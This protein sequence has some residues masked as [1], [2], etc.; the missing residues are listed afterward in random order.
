MPRLTSATATSD[1]GP[2]ART[3]TRT[4]ATPT[5][6]ETES[7]I[8]TAE[9]EKG[10]QEEA[11]EEARRCGPDVG[12]PEPDRHREPRSQRLLQ[13][14]APVRDQVEAGIGGG[15]GGQRVSVDGLA[16]SCAGSLRGP[17]V[18]W[19]ARCASLAC[20]PRHV[21]RC[22]GHVDLAPIRA[23][24]KVL[25]RVAVA[26]PRGE[27]HG[28]ER[29]PGAERQ[30]DQADALHELRPVEP[31]D[32]A[33][34]R[35]DVPDRDVHRGLALVLQPDR[36]FSRRS[37]RRQK[38]LE[39]AE[40]RRCGWVLVAKPLE[41]LDLAR[42]RQGRAGQLPELGGRG[43]G[44]R[45]AE[46]QQAVRQV[47]CALA[48]FAAADDLLGQASEVLDQQDAQAD[49]DR[50]ELSERQRLH[51]LVRHHQATQALRIES[52]VGVRDVCPRETEDPRISLEGAVDELWQLAVV[53][54]GQVVADLAELLL[55]DVEV[56][57]EPLRGRRDRSLVLDRLGQLAV[58]LQEQAPVL[59]HPPGDRTSRSR[60]TGDGLGGGEGFAV[61]LEALDAEQFRDDRLR[62][63]G[64]APGLSRNADQ[65]LP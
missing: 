29:A 62:I 18:R 4:S 31:G 30:V 6:P 38:A 27:V 49:G 33:H 15:R 44:G 46:P 5:P 53:V 21:H 28:P 55:D 60:T 32:Q 56:V 43:L 12:A 39:Q 48:G 26:I 25:D 40:C 11:H 7:A 9:D 61:L 63:V 34:A 1:A 2:N 35:D 42:G 47:V 16:G 3:A 65:R 52:T 23:T 14:D 17:V 58:G 36:L 37:L 64:D 13:R 54:R 22:P 45:L 10:R 24:G 19:A 51:P 8:G 59:G 20:L 41:E 57:D 50:P